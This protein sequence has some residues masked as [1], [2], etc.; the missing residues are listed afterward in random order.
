MVKVIFIGNRYN[1]IRT[2][3]EQFN[4]KVDLVK[5]LVLKDS[6]LESELSSQQ[7][8]C[9][10]FALVDKPEII[11][12]IK[13]TP[14]DILVSN[15]CPFILP[16][17][18]LKTGNQVFMNVHPTYLPYLK[19]KTPINGVFFNQMTFFGATMHLMND[20]VDEGPILHQQKV[21]LTEDIDLPM[22]Y[23]MSFRLE[24]EVFEEGFNKYLNSGASAGIPQETDGSYFDRKPEYQQFSFSDSTSDVIKTIRAF[25]ITS[26]GAI[27]EL[28]GK[29]IKVFSATEIKNGTFK[30]WYENKPT[31]TIILNLDRSIYVR[32]LDGIVRIERYEWI[33]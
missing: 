6:P 33:D 3:L 24:G 30:K 27:A 10:T 20:Q 18:E 25:G 23:H 8:A 21:E 7:I 22:L 14:F 16:V 26:Q 17:S 12:M 9:H 31:G 11:Q 4:G 29:K 2:L 32:T 13:S 28:E 5:T 19:G 15:G 1:V